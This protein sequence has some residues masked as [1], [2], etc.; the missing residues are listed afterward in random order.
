MKIKEINKV[1]LAA[2]GFKRGPLGIRGP[3]SKVR[4]SAYGPKILVSNLGNFCRLRNYI[5][6]VRIFKRNV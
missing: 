2:V 5:N 3:I 1:R 6:S 4:E